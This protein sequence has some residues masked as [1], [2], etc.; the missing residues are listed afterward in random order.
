MNKLREQYRQE[1]GNEVIF[2]RPDGSSSFL[3]RY[4]EWLENRLEDRK[5]VEV[6]EFKRYF[7]YSIL[8][9]ENGRGSW[10][11]GYIITNGCYP[12]LNC[13]NNYHSIASNVLNITNVSEV[14]T[15]EDLKDFIGSNLQD[16]ITYTKEKGFLNPIKR[17]EFDD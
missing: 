7:I 11:Y 9:V 6:K 14:K 5:K 12:N 3:P 15:I 16:E 2:T 10:I 8:E 17:S 1:T 13:I 4:V